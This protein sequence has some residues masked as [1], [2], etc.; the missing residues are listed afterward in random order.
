MESAGLAE[1]ASRA[2]KS[3][4]AQRLP[5]YCRPLGSSSS[6]S[7]PAQ[8]QERRRHRRRGSDDFAK[9]QR[10][11]QRQQQQ[12]PQHQE[13]RHGQEGREEGREGYS[14]SKLPQQRRQQQQ[15][16]QQRAQQQQQPQK[17]PY[18]R[19][20]HNQRPNI[21]NRRPELLR[22]HSSPAPMSVREVPPPTSSRTR[23]TSPSVSSPPW[24]LLPVKSTTADHD[25]VNGGG[26]D[27]GKQA[28]DGGWGTTESKRWLTG[29]TMGEGAADSK[30]WLAEDEGAGRAAGLKHWP[31]GDVE[32]ASTRAMLQ[33]N[34]QRGHWTG[35]ETLMGDFASV[36]SRGC[37]FELV[38]PFNDDSRDHSR[39]LSKNINAGQARE[40][41]VSGF[42]HEE[43]SIGEGSQKTGLNFGLGTCFNA[44]SQ[45]YTHKTLL[46]CASD[47][48]LRRP[49]FRL[50]DFYLST[51]LSLSLFIPLSPSL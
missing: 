28:S 23:P 1:E 19:P 51:S 20:D 3:T 5:G 9:Q 6:C 4:R 43:R 10:R 22:K 24:L 38:F 2:A 45:Q 12:Q 16:Q 33:N 14:Q 46:P 40:S 37:G 18:Q 36:G 42:R 39:C 41:K 13:H 34:S 32:G 48:C 44:P 47:A 50:L 7:P 29:N 21:N 25:S 26:G 8:E 11:Q 17:R 30:L 35:K 31:T 27:S 15:Q 49:L